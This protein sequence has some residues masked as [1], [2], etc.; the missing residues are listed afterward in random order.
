MLTSTAGVIVEF[1]FAFD[2]CTLKARAVAGPAALTAVDW[3]IFVLL[4]AAGSNSDAVTLAVF[5]I[6]GAAAAWG[7]TVTLTTALAALIIVPRLQVSTP[8]AGVAQVPWVG[9]AETNVE[10]A[11]SV[12][13][14]VT[15]VA[16]FGPLLV[17]VIV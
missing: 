15:T 10:L 5:V 2:G 9:V 11:G 8:A 14:R 4:L 3:V 7:V 6:N 12:S 17:M 16:L 13:V 1:M